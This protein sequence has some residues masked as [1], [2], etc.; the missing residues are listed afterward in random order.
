[1]HIHVLQQTSQEGPEDRFTGRARLQQIAVPEPP[2]AV[3]HVVRVRF[4][5][6][7]RTA[8]HR[9]PRGQILYILSGTGLVQERGGPIHRVRAGTVVITP[10]NAEHWHGA[11][12]NTF[13]THLAVQDVDEDWLDAYWGPHVSDSE[14][15]GLT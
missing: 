11:A 13:M 9:H 8:W 15:S 3:T 1:M 6:A 5:P 12:P 4:D 10:P 2:G 7:A 14:Y